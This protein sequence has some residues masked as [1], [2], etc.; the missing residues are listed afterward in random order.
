MVVSAGRGAFQ[1]ALTR[2]SSQAFLLKSTVEAS[3]VGAG[4]REAVAVTGGR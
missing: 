3:S 1:V 4:Y 2:A